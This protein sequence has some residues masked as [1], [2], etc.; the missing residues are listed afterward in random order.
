M[1]RAGR[2]PHSSFT[3]R[4]ALEIIAVLGFLASTLHLSNAQFG[5]VDRRALLQGAGRDAGGGLSE[6]Q[7]LLEDNMSPPW[8]P[9]NYDRRRQSQ[10]PNQCGT[11]MHSCL[12]VGFPTGCCLNNQYCFVMTNWTLGCCRIG[13]NC[14]DVT[15]CSE[16]LYL[17]NGTISVTKLVTQITTVGP[18]D[19]PTTST[20]VN[21]LI[22]ASVS[23]GCGSNPCSR[24]SFL[25][26]A[27]FGGQCCGYG[28]ICASNSLC[29]APV[30]PTPSAIV[31]LTPPECKAAT[32]YACI[33]GNKTA[34]CCATGQ[35]CVGDRFCSGIPALP[36]GS[37]ATIETSSEL[38]S[39][40]RAGIGAG[41]AVGA[42][43]VIGLLTWFCVRRR[44]EAKA[45][46]SRRQS[47]ATGS[48]LPPT[49]GHPNHNTASGGRRA[50]G[51]GTMS[52]DLHAGRR[53][54][55]M[56]EI[57]GPTSGG[58]SGNRPPL[59]QSGLVYDYFGPDAV[60]GPYTDDAVTTPYFYDDEGRA[61][62]ATGL[63]RT[64]SRGVPAIP[65]GP[66]DI[67]RPVEIGESASNTM[68]RGVRRIE[69]EPNS[70]STTPEAVEGVGHYATPAKATPVF[71]GSGPGAGAA[72]GAGAS[73]GALAGPRLEE[74]AIGGTTIITHTGTSPAPLRPWRVG[75]F[76]LASP[77]GTTAA[78]AP[79]TTTQGTAGVGSGVDGAGAGAGAGVG[80]TGGPL[81]SYEDEEAAAAT[82]AAAAVAEGQ[83][84]RSPWRGQ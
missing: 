3:T 17:Q 5:A 2:P 69:G 24:S 27:A 36:T 41:V 16:G 38:S 56:S 58:M 82:A 11:E 46:A 64:P 68:R 26:Q 50:A 53:E 9:L 40:A 22:T 71:I 76:E 30:T 81:R 45:A 60:P 18:L 21:Q 1:A 39:Q 61:V 12:D 20:R 73:P 79:A 35:T 59:H 77:H 75:P 13:N 4:S 33:P 23:P 72:A 42:A 52:P 78:G 32:E 70:Y 49:S 14:L 8:P 51:S 80:A 66:G 6:R 84:G 48:H 7:Y 54:H 55:T 83:R 31:P 10:T 28:S 62:G 67:S 57:S 15:P 34:G 74:P 63:D 25:C 47:T 29:I 43:I 19:D 37:N 44:R 65:R